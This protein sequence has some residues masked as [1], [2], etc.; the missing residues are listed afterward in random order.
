[1]DYG[2]R[3]SPDRKRAILINLMTLNADAYS[4]SFHYGIQNI[5]GEG[6]TG[7][8]LYSTASW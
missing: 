2:R 1:M 3:G 6:T 7:N 8:E 4:N 5:G